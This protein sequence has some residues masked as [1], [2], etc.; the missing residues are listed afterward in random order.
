MP[1]SGFRYIDSNETDKK[2]KRRNDLK[3]YD[4]L[5]SHPSHGLEVGVARY[6]HHQ[7]GKYNGD[8]DRFYQAYENGTE[9]FEFR[10]EARKSKPDDQSCQHSDEDEVG[11]RE[12]SASFQAGTPLRETSILYCGCDIKNKSFLPQKSNQNSVKQATG[13]GRSPASAQNPGTAAPVLIEF[14]PDSVA[15]TPKRGT[16]FWEEENAETEY[17]ISYVPPHL[18]LVF[19]EAESVVA[20]QPEVFALL[21][22]VFALLSAVVELS[23][24]VVVVL[25]PELEVVFAAQPEVFALLSEVLALAAEPEVV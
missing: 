16:A 12:P 24:E 19:L 20:A 17:P 25:V 5:H 18:F 10:P 15:S 23:P 6:A 2:C 14:V 21:A 13:N 11:L 4:C 7:G 8:N 3:V 1:Q 22:E 9:R